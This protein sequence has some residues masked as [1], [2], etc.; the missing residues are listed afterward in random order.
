MASKEEDAKKAAKEHW[1]STVQKVEQKLVSQ[2]E[3]LK[4]HTNRLHPDEEQNRNEDLLNTQDSLHRLNIKKDSFIKRIAKKEMQNWKRNL[5]SQKGKN[6][7]KYR[8]DRGAED[9]VY[10]ALQEQLVAHK[11]RTGVPILEKRIQRKELR[12][13]ANNWLKNNGKPLIKSYET[14]RS[15]GKPCNKRSQQ[16]KQHRGKGLFLH[17]RAKKTFTNVHLNI[18]YNRAHI[19]YYTR[20]IFSTKRKHLYSQYTIRRCFDDKAYLRCGTSEGFSRPKSR[21]VMLVE[22]EPELPAYD[23]PEK[24]GYVSPGVSLIIKDM[25]EKRIN[26]RDTFATTDVTISVTCKPKVSYPSSASNWANDMYMD[27]MEF[28]EEHELEGTG[29]DSL[30]REVKTSLVFLR[31]SLKQFKLMTLQEDYIK[32]LQGGDHV[33]REKLRL[34]VLIVRALHVTTHRYS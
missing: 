33:K 18:H 14:V 11:S 6:L 19:K 30:S 25:V 10:C 31:D 20:Y 21:P 9:A 16:S 26:D 3:D 12:R 7:G 17:K 34:S 4:R 15:W 22:S 29:L 32:A 2:E 27:R 28:P 13:I 23:F 5:F 24:A 1:L 8:I